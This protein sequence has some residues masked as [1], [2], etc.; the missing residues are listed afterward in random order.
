MNKTN[1]SYLTETYLKKLSAKVLEV[2]VKDK[3]TS[4][5]L[6]K[7]IFYP[8]GGGQACDQGI[9]K[10]KSGEIKITN[11]IYNNGNPLHQGKL[12][13]DIKTGDVVDCLIDWDRRYRNMRL[14]S[15]GH[16]VH[17]V[18]HENYPEL[19]PVRA[20]HG[21]GGEKYIEYEGKAGLDALKLNLRLQQLITDDLP[22]SCYFV[23]LDE[24]RAKAAFV[25]ENL[26]QNKPLRVA[27]IGEYPPIPDGGTQVKSTK[28][29]IGTTISNIELKN[30]L[31]KV[32]YEADIEEDLNRF[33]VIARNDK[34]SVEKSATKG[35]ANWRTFRG[36]KNDDISSVKNN[37]IALISGAE[38][39]E[40]L[41]ELRIKY[42]GRKGEINQLMAKLP[43]LTGDER[44][45]FGRNVNE[46]KKTIETVLEQKQGS[47]NKFEI[48]PEYFDPTMPGITPKI[49]ALHP[50]T[51]IFNEVE[52]IFDRFGFTV[53]NG[54][55]I[56]WDE[57]NFQKLLLGPDH[58]SRDTQETY[59]FDDKRLLRVHTSSVQVRY[60]QTHQPPIRIISPGRVYRRDT[61]DATHLPSF[62]Q[63]EGLMI[64]DHTTLSDLLGVLEYFVK[65]LLGQKRKVR[66]YGHHFP[67]TEPSL[68]VEV[69]SQNGKWL[70][71]LGC[72]MVHPQVLKNCGIDNKR[73]QGWAFGMGAD[74][75]AMLKY[76]ISDIR[77]L[78]EGNL[79]FLNQNI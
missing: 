45:T 31:I 41:E 13:G 36:W 49:G 32:N 44:K 68:E 28:E 60:M 10:G 9:I 50:I 55:E 59:Y 5:I 25:P 24:L 3:T 52:D 77:Q 39:S 64:D 40:E 74:R 46:A 65:Q 43:K 30:N 18:I 63:I 16:L 53:A 54:P 11:I 29:L 19:V 23:T 72:G 37:A 56:E 2:S 48:S 62:H 58:P 76:E 20:Q 14:H 12:N 73:Y 47:F 57:I 78:I 22:V 34:E 79:K 21:I 27:Q 4:V 8:Q 7:T 15:A 71:I 42:L 38:S 33:R 75:L 66:F 61:V 69:L 51:K 17:E 70:E 6:D 1:L 67:Y 35:S 26:P